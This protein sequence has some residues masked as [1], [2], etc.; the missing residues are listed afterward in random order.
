[1]NSPMRGETHYTLTQLLEAR[2]RSLINETSTKESAFAAK[3]REHYE[4]TVPEHARI[5]EWST[6]TDPATRMLRDAE[7][8]NRWFRDD[9]NARFPADVIEAFIAAF[10]HD[11]RFALQEAI[12]ARQDLLA[13][14]MPKS[15]PGADGENLGRVAKETAQAILDLSAMLDDGVIDKNDAERAPKAIE[16]IEKAMAVLAEMRKRIERQALGME[17]TEK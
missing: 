12:A 7:K 5:V 8:I 2:W 4:A 1:M 11:R 13:V 9:V 3:V 10:P 6:R 17:D 16:D 15:A 14:P